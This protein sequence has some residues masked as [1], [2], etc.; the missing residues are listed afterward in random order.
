MGARIELQG[1]GGCAPMLIEGGPLKG[2]EY[3]LPV[4]S[5]QVKSCV[6][7]AGLMADGLT[8]VIEPKPTRDHTERLLKT[9][10]FAITVDGLRITVEGSGGEPIHCKGRNWH[11]PGDFSSAAFF[12]AAAAGRPGAAL[13]IENVGLNPRRDVL[14]DVL[15]RMGADIRIKDPQPDVDG[16]PTGTVCV[17]GA[18]LKGVEVGGAE[19]PALIDELPLV[20]VLGAVAEGV[21]TIRDAAEL[22]V[23][24]SD[25]IACMVEN[26]RRLEVDV[27]ERE[28]GMVIRG[29]A[30][31]DAEERINSYGDHRVAMAM[32]V[33]ALYARQPLCINNTACVATSYP[34]FWEDLRGL[35]VYVEG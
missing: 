16:E 4:A 10:G 7:L 13:E 23:K 8:I 6:L 28:D 19:I 11:I 33:L 1:E 18:V 35:G 27:E 12:I 34:G 25:R 24:E 5:A 3:T 22:R 14:L 15:K 32:A 30:R 2:I 21:T 9:L 20:A 17:Q 31:L 29:P 26:L